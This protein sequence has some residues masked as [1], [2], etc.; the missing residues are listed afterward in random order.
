MIQAL[1]IIPNDVTAQNELVS[2]EQ[3]CMPPDIRNI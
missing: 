2:I 3:A 1:R